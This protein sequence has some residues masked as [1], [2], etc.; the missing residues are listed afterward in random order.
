MRILHSAITAL[1]LCNASLVA[2][3]SAW[4]FQDA[5]VQV[6]SKA[7]DGG[8]KL[9]KEK[10]ASSIVTEPLRKTVLINV[11]SRLDPKKPLGAP[12]TLTSSDSVRVALTTVEDKKAQRPHQA[13]LTLTEPRTGIEESF[14]LGIKESGKGG[15][16]I[17]R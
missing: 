5:T 17:V 4:G 7:D 6:Q 10:Y 13:F 14:P 1:A 16:N 15:I 12:L 8:V 11:Q 3:A 2:A 9:N